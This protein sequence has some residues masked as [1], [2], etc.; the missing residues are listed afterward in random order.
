[1]KLKIGLVLMYIAF[2]LIFSAAIYMLALKCENT[3]C[4]RG[5][6]DEVGVLV[7]AAEINGEE[8]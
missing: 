3:I 2:G 4:D 6:R 1:M 8:R 7:F 5:E